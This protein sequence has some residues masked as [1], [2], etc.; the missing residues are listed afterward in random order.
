MESG[1]GRAGDGAKRGG[2]PGDDKTP[3]HRRMQRRKICRF[4]AERIPID[5]KDVRLLGSF[6]TERGKLVPS[7]IT[8][9]CSRHQRELTTAVKRARNVA[10]LPF[11]IS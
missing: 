4:C 8:G 10:L 1:R 5:Y 11:A 2:R 3:H 7:R 6:I 9:N